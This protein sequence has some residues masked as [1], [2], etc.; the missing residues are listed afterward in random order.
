MP[1]R[2]Q[3]NLLSCLRML[4]SRL[5][6]VV[7]VL[8]DDGTKD[9]DSIVSKLCSVQPRLRKPENRVH[10]NLWTP[11]QAVLYFSQRRRRW[12]PCTVLQVNATTGAVTLS[13]KPDK[14]I[15]KDEAFASLALSAHHPHTAESLPVQACRTVFLPKQDPSGAL[16]LTE[17]D[18]CRFFVE[19]EDGY[20]HVY[21]RAS[22]EWSDRSEHG[23]PMGSIIRG[24]DEGDGWVRFLIEAQHGPRDDSPA[25]STRNPES[26]TARS[27]QGVPGPAH[28]SEAERRLAS[29]ERL[30][31]SPECSCSPSDA[32]A[33][34]RRDTSASDIDLRL[35]SPA[36]PTTTDRLRHM[37]AQPGSTP[38]RR[39]GSENN[40]VL[41][42]HATMK[43]LGIGM[44][45]DAMLESC[46]IM[47][48]LFLESMPPAVS[49]VSI[50]PVLV[51]SQWRRFWAQVQRDS[52]VVQAA[53]TG[54]GYDT[55]H[56]T[57]ERGLR[58]GA[59]LQETLG[60]DACLTSHAGLAHWH[61]Q[62]HGDLR[63]MLVVLVGAEPS[64]CKP[65]FE[66]C[67][68]RNE[69]L[70]PHP[71]HY[72]MRESSQ[73]VVSHLVTY[74]C[75]VDEAALALALRNA[76]SRVHCDQLLRR[77]PEQS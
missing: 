56:S 71:L 33:R 39:L 34:D 26:F 61:T 16:V 8:A 3:D 44:H 72:C 54:T 57:I 55:A 25:S 21:F 76:V 73:L 69:D 31:A 53:F 48:D 42:Q 38:E 20:T 1:D 46:K 32:R 63:R 35:S 15:S 10:T 23:V 59:K 27:L 37:E 77:G 36:Q 43:E 45:R 5:T 74:S 12:F 62:P 24:H 29:L 2:F 18:S 52:S 11:G 6:N 66:G 67:V 9:R 65:L 13:I 64:A 22:K 19:Y 47:V 50:E 4:R 51:R 41:V 17:K 60:E 75:R 7:Y 68:E 28:L 40:F 30:F 58:K 14:A 49:V 70:L